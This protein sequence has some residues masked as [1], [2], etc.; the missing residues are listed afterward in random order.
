MD[1]KLVDQ[2]YLK[3]ESEYKTKKEV[4]E[5]IK[6]ELGLDTKTD[7][8]KKAHERY[9]KKK[10]KR[11]DKETGQ[12]E[13]KTDR[14][15]GQD[16]KTKVQ[17]EIILNHGKQTDKEI[18][19]KLGVSNGA[20]YKYKKQVRLPMIERSQKMLKESLEF[21]YPD[22]EEIL[23]RIK[24]KKRNILINGIKII[25]ESPTDKDIQIGLRRA[26]SNIQEIEK[27]IMEDLQVIGIDKQAEYEKQL[28]RENID[29]N[30]FELD[31]EKVNGKDEGDIAIVL[32]KLKKGGVSSLSDEEL[33]ILEE[34][35]TNENDRL[36]SEN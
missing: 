13:D 12:K 5:R 6:R 18:M 20:F 35:L 23:K 21:A 10:E 1:I 30:R 8:I 31:K 19:E 29:I 9:L 14:T 15:T 27:E 26:I 32:M 28:V 34:F 25:E 11:Q 33:K 4:Y 17:T 24:G 22:E 2:L 7:S 36:T 3:L 16:K